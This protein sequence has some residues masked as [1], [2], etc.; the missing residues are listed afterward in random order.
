LP[1]SIIRRHSANV[2]HTFPFFTS[3]PVTFM[4]RQRMVWSASEAVLSE[5]LANLLPCGIGA[6]AGAVIGAE[7][8]ASAKA[9]V[10][11]PMI[12]V[13]KRIGRMCKFL[14]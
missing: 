4:V 6:D 1:A 8:G 11:K 14:R 9:D 12:K 3:E 2:L 7:A 13:V 5:A 10:M